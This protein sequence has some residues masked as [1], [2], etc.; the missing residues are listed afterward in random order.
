MRRYL[1]HAVSSGAVIC[2]STT[3]WKNNNSLGPRMMQNELRKYGEIC[4]NTDKISYKKKQN[5]CENEITI[6]FIFP[7]KKKFDQ[8]NQCQFEGDIELYGSDKRDL[9]R[10]ILVVIVLRVKSHFLKIGLKIREIS[11]IATF[12]SKNFPGWKF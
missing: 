9:K 6:F 3:N 5:R 12:R 10:N 1:K 4:L 7:P 8:N 2:N 11:R